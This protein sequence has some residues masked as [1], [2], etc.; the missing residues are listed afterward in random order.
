M[1]REKKDELPKMQLSF[2]DVI[3]L[4]LYKTLS[5]IFPWLQP[6]YD[7]CKLNRKNWQDLAEKVDMG[8]TW[9]DHDFIEKPVEEFTGTD[10]VLED[11]NLVVTTLNCATGVIEGGGGAG[12]GARFKVSRWLRSGRKSGSRDSKESNCSSLQSPT[13]VEGVVE[14]L[15]C[16][17]S[18]GTRGDRTDEVRMTKKRTCS[19]C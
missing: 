4:P 7:G 3:C 11:V 18:D 6:L 12:K 2:I 9:I 14:M 5:E 16:E 19:I 13:R 15:E 10:V 17:S 8:L 1:D